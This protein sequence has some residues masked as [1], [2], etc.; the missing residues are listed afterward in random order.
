MKKG[1]NFKTNISVDDNQLVN[2]QLEISDLPEDWLQE[3]FITS[4]SRLRKYISE[5]FLSCLKNIGASEV[6]N[7]EEIEFMEK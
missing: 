7:N 2:L 3:Y 6:I 5:V 4:E 1:I